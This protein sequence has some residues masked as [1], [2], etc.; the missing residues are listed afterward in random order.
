MESILTS[1]KQMLGIME[2]DTS[3]DQDIIVHINSTFMT[4]QDIGVGPEDGYRIKD[5]SETWTDFLSGNKKAEDVKTYVYLK[6]RIL[7]DPPANQST[8]TAFKEAANE[9]EW[10]LNVRNDKTRLVD[11]EESDA[12]TVINPSDV[13]EMWDEND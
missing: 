13:D 12:I 4:L 8:L 6:V 2:D 7:F 10:R 9:F 1:I 11:L 3:F 5:K